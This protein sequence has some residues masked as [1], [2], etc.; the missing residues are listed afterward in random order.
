V[1]YYAAQ[2]RLLRY[3][4]HPTSFSLSGAVNVPVSLRVGRWSGRLQSAAA[5]FAVTPFASVDAD[6]YVTRIA[7]H[8]TADGRIPRTL[9]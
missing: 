5:P 4:K 2:A 9:Q 6:F 7:R 8:Y 1:L 3:K